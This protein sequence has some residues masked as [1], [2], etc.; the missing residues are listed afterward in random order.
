MQLIRSATTTALWSILRRLKNL[1]IL[2]CYNTACLAIWVAFFLGALSYP[3][4]QYTIF[5]HSRPEQAFSAV[6]RKCHFLLAVQKD[7]HLILGFFPDD[8]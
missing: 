2:F 8:N 6:A 3:C 1:A 7:F 5:L 4:G